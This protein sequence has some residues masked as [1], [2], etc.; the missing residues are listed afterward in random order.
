[1]PGRHHLYLV[2]GFFG[3]TNLGELRYFAH[4]LDFLRGRSRA[5]GV[6]AEIHVVRTHPTASLPQRAARVVETVAETMGRAGAVHVIGHSSGGLD[7]PLAVAPG[8]SLPSD[9]NVQRVARRGR[10]GVTAATPHQR[11][12][13]ASLFPS[14]L[15]QRPLPFPSLLAVYVLRF[16]PLPLSAVAQL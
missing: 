4:V 7:A 8:G 3:F 6:R 1:M 9:A 10:T 2:P 15:R 16:G 5:L 12:P 13:P 11:A 14:L